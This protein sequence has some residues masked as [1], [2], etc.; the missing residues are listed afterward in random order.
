MPFAWWNKLHPIV[1]RLMLPHAIAVMHFSMYSVWNC[2]LF[3]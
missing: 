2:T 1:A 3:C